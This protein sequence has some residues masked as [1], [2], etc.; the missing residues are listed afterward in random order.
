MKRIIVNVAITWVSEGFYP[1]RPNVAKFHFTY[2]KQ[3]SY[4]FLLKT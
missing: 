4:T 1:G 2:S 3:R